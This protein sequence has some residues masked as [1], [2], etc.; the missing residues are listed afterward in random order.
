MK[1]QI[2]LTDL[3]HLEEHAG[4]VVRLNP[5][6]TDWHMIESVHGQIVMLKNMET[7]N[8]QTLDVGTTDIFLV[9]P[10]ELF[11]AFGRKTVTPSIDS[12][13]CPS[14]KGED[15]YCVN[16][17]LEKGWEVRVC[18]NVVCQA[19]YDVYYQTKAMRAIVRRGGVGNIGMTAS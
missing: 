10:S 18:E 15:T 8:L 2:K 16:D 13:I 4:Q 19:L 3:H 14:C 9:E 11:Q 7:G 1:K 5:E 6:A 12:V 17:F